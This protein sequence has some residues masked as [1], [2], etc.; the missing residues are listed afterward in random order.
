A[1]ALRERSEGDVNVRAALFHIAG[2]ALGAIAVIIGGIAIALTHRAWIDPALSLFVA[3]LIV[4]GVIR[5]MR[6]ASDVL[7]ESVPAGLNV[8]AVE[9]RLRGIAGVCGVHDLHV[10]AIGSASYALSA[11]VLLDDRTISEAASVLREIDQCLK[12]DFQIGHVTVQFECDNCPVV[13]GH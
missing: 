7:L 8:D 10:W 13:V 4:A 12:A 3:A 6:D 2:D 11:H 9:A 1:L 5:L